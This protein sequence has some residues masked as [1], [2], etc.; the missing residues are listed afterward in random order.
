MERK[1]F[2]ELITWKTAA[3]TA[4]PGLAAGSHSVWQRTRSTFDRSGAED[5][6][7]ALVVAGGGMG[8]CAAAL[9]ALRNGLTVIMTEVT[10]WVG[11]QLTSQGVP[12]HEHCQDESHGLADLPRQLRNRLRNYSRPHSRL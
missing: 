8:G 2:L 1:D 7:A 12:P 10:A 11:G 3:I 5:L 9:G 6:S 4:L